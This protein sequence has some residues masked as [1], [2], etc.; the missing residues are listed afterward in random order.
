MVAINC[1][2]VKEYRDDKGVEC[3]GEVVMAGEAVR[4][5]GTCPAS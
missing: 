5:K 4:R 3:F 2:M 1:K